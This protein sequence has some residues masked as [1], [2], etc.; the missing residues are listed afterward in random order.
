MSPKFAQAVDPIFLHVF[1]VLERIRLGEHLAAEEVA[2][3]CVREF[4]RAEG[5]LGGGAAWGLAKYGLAAWIDAVLSD[6]PWS[7]SEW[8]KENALEVRFGGRRNTSVDF[9]AKA[10][11]ALTLSNKDALEVYYVC[12]VLGFRGAYADAGTPKGDQQ[13]RELNLPPSLP[14]WT[15]RVR[16]AIRLGEGRPPIAVRSVP[17]DGAP[18]LDGKFYLVGAAFMTAI[19]TVTLCFLA[20]ALFW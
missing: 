10:N 4:D 15:K 20:Y 3:A 19:L 1:E 6:A 8:W 2:N 17:G 16:E 5:Q 13:L 18:P 9:F 11:E 7:G 12:V 14:D